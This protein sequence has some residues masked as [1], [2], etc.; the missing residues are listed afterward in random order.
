MSGGIE[1]K[2]LSGRDIEPY[3]GDM[4]R[5]RIEVF[6][7][8][9]YLYDG[10]LEY[11][12]RYLQTYV[13]SPDSILVL[14]IDEGRVIGASTGLPME[15]ETEEFKQPFVQHGYDPARIFYCGESVLQRAY[16]GRGIYKQFFTGRE[17]QARKLG[18]FD[19][20]SFCCVVRPADHP[21]RPADYAPLD[22]IWTKFGYVRHPE[23]QTSYAWKDVGESE[24]TDK[25]MVFWLKA[26][27]GNA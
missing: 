1:I 26:I 6:R 10:T 27:G 4:A 20:C 9:P 13:E 8:F 7:E 16:R 24:E 22:P 15:H 21:L 5:L 23:L 17:G 19:Y 25:P 2:H 11:E 14:A 3:L 18:R 12:E